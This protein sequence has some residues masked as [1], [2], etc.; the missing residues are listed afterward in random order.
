MQKRKT[1]P[2]AAPHDPRGT[3]LAI[4]VD[5]HEVMLCAKYELS[6]PPSSREEDFLRFGDS[7]AMATRLVHGI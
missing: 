1:G 7:V 5:N 2:G 4:L 3:I 6:R